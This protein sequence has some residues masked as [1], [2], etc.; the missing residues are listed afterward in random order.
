MIHTTTDYEKFDFSSYNRPIRD[1]HIKFLKKQIKKQGLLQ[2]LLVTSDGQIVD[3]QHRF[4][5]CRELGVPVQYVVRDGMSMGDVVELNNC[6]MRWTLLDKV[7]SY[8]AQ[9]VEDYIKL[10]D[11]YRLCL[12]VS[13]KFSVKSAAF[14]A[15]G[16]ATQTTAQG[17]KQ[18]LGGGTWK[19]PDDEDAAMARLEAIAQFSQWKFF[20]QNSFI[21]AFLRCMRTVEGFDHEELLRKAEMNPHVFMHA[22]TTEEYMRMF[23]RV[24]NHR[25]SGR[26]YKRF[27]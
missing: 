27:F 18:N 21:T 15:Q 26:N 11:L 3:G 16:A 19:F 13:P 22:G 4:H 5:A 7:Q 8:A 2:P 25:K 14:I 10:M 23:E 12:E 20:T 9:G 6:A 17:R 24:Y 1:P